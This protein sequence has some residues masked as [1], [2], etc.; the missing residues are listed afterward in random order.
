MH[1]VSLETKGFKS[2]ADKTVINFNERITGIVGPNGCG[3]SNIVDSIRWVLGEQ[4]TS[5]LRSDK[6]ENIIFNGSKKR[7]ASSLAEVS[8]T[9]ENT[10]N[11][12]PTEYT[13]ITITRMLYRNGDSEYRLNGIPC[14]LKDITNLFLDTGVGSDSYAIIELGMVDEILN[15]RE[16]SRRKLFEQ[17]AGISKYK[18]R[19]KETLQK[20]SATE[21]DL[22]RIEDLL[23]EIND[24]L[25]KLESQAKRAKRYHQLKKDYKL[26]SIELAKF[27]LKSFSIKYDSLFKQISSEED[28][29]LSI[30]TDIKQLDAKIEKEKN[31]SLEKE[32][33]L[34]TIQRSL[35]EKLH[36][37]REQENQKNLFSEKVK[38]LSDKREDLLKHAEDAIHNLHELNNSLQI[39]E[40]QKQE[41][42]TK[43]N[44]AQK[45]LNTLSLTQDQARK[46]QDDRRAE[47]EQ[48]KS[49]YNQL[50]IELNEN[51]KQLQINS[52]QLSALEKTKQISEEEKLLKEQEVASLQQQ[53]VDSDKQVIAQR[54]LL[55]N[56]FS[57]NDSIN[58][59]IIDQEEE[60][61]DTQNA[62]LETKRKLDAKQNEYNLIKNLVDNLEGFPESVKFLKKEV[63]VT[64]D[65]PLLSDII[66]CEEPY[67]VA[68]E[69]YL[70][71]FLNYYI[72][73]TEAEAI[74]AINILS[75]AAKGRA[76]FF[77]LD[78]VGQVLPANNNHKNGIPA[79]RVISV[80]E[81]YKSLCAHLLNNV[82]IVDTLPAQESDEI[83]ITSNGRLIKKFNS[84]S[85][86]AVGLFEG[87]K[88]GRRKSLETLK[89]AIE[90]LKKDVDQLSA[91]GDKKKVTI[92]A[93]KSSLKNDQAIS[94]Q[95]E[96][97]KLDNQ[98]SIIKSKIEDHISFIEVNKGKKEENTLLIET[99][100]A[101]NSVIEQNIQQLNLNINNLQEALADKEKNF[102]I[103]SEEVQ[104][105]SDQYNQ[106]NILFHQ[107]QGE[108]KRIEQDISF[109]QNQLTTNQERL[110]STQN[111]LTET[112]E[113]IK[114]SFSNTS[115]LE[116]S[117]IKLY[118][119][120]EVAEH[121]RN[122]FEENYYKAKGNVH[123]L[124]QQLKNLTR[125]RDQ[126]ETILSEL[127]EKVNELKL[128]IASLKERL[129][130][131]FKI[132]I[133]DIIEQSPEEGL[134]QQEL[135]EITLKLK[136]RLDNYGEINPMAV[137]AYDE[138][139]KRADFIN[140]QKNDLLSAKSSLLE[141]IEE[142]DA[143][144]KEKFMHAFTEVREN[145]IKVFHSLFS[146]EDTCDLI[147]T[148]EENP[149][150]ASIEI[151][152]KPKGKKPLTINQLS[153]GEKTLTA[154][155]LLFSLYL[156]KPAPFCIFDEVDAPLDDTN[157]A[158]FN[159]IIKD[160]SI[161][162]QFIIVTHNKQ[163]M[164][165]MDVMYG[166]TMAEEGVSKLVPVDFRSLKE[167]S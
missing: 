60:Y 90:L 59:K 20:L 91:T 108:V 66:A 63:A 97:N 69:N 18:S 140:E 100:K 123:E 39:A 6:M 11:V 3:K 24:N 144:A 149:L 40:Q 36:Q 107:I 110:L 33:Q 83:Y 103:I 133:E 29:K 147:L 46:Q 160:F 82:A 113:S 93:L 162:S 86:G 4:K 28:K 5:M 22:D 27:S 42:E 166:V 61:A 65:A 151:I 127:K 153:G 21:N 131:E 54:E 62:L 112:D 67:R 122:A 30:E 148:D 76:N 2:F 15:D 38:F 14:R 104:K 48:L 128:S 1:L 84:I 136:S 139:Q 50:K 79:V 146:E 134:Q 135:E 111:S 55:E 77:I 109:K 68:I 53:L 74:T 161:D 154:T 121:S 23:F 130:I 132:N 101:E 32:K 96:I 145:F 117:L 94:L 141:T 118:E 124:E 52:A 126:A 155:A 70:E 85:G 13:T 75:D 156:L 45:D 142:I 114:S 10:K 99:L 80:E 102:L 34:A 167:A 88:I 25:K 92:N 152:A 87:K 143:K 41:A 95:S 158:K 9:F 31:E 35:N 57:E 19:K 73:Q 120:K 16:H 115:N 51:D 163:T 58:K 157:I 89:T 137:E 43:I 81:K 8:L 105:L 138:M 165:H 12:L 26:N 164:S 159:K 72:V 98:Q 119:E 106:Q 116:R 56:V 37:L 150:E 47:L 71:P 78:K 129:D 44:A 7:K 64:K 125:N 49:T 17:A